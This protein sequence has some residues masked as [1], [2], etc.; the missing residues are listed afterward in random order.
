MEKRLSGKVALVT[1]AASG[2]GRAI[3]L[4]LA[5]E[6]ASVSAVDMNLEG[7]QATAKQVE[8]SGVRAVALE[9]DVSD[10]EAAKQAVKATEDGL[11][12]VG[13]LVNCA[14]SFVGNNFLGDMLT[15]DWQAML[16][17]HCNGMFFFTR[18]V[19]GSMTEGDRVINISSIDGVGGQVLGT[20]YSA[21]KAGMIGFTH[22]LALEVGHRGITVN[23]IAPGVIVTPMGQLLV[24]AC[25][26]FYERIPIR[27]FGQPEDIAHLTA[28]LASP[29]AGYITGQTIVVDGGL[30][31]ANPINNFVLGMMG[32]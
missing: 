9:C 17:V 6:G 31:L 25:P 16:D 22:T 28:F 4:E 27:R 32:V 29:G 23:A 24:D 8:N 12:R 3:A 10:E 1:G 18:A 30:T 11:G 14:G 7:A 5:S 13:I 2:I 20:H 21:A 15:E 26:D 19:I